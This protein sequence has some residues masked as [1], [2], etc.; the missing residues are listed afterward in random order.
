VLRVEH[1]LYPLVVNSVAGGKTTLDNCA[2]P[3]PGA[4]VDV[5]PAFTLLPHD[6][7]RLAENIELTLGC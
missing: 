5:R 4:P 2:L 3:K 7:S 6:E 1:I